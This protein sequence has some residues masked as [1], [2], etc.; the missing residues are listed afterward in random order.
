MQQRSH[1][2]T[3]KFLDPGCIL[4]SYAPFIPRAEEKR[5]WPDERFYELILREIPRIYDDERGYGPKGMNF[6]VHADVPAEVMQSYSIIKR[7]FD[8]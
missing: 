8:Q 4:V 5:P 6:I 2:G 3:L 1:L 7:S